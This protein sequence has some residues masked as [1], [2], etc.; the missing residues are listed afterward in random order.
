MPRADGGSRLI[1][2]GKTELLSGRFADLLS[3][4]GGGGSSSEA[5]AAGAHGTIATLSRDEGE[6]I[7]ALCK[8][9]KG[10]GTGREFHDVRNAF[11]ELL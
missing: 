8:G 5:S 6:S 1:L 10:E 4:E 7:D 11:V 2:E 3:G 9:Q